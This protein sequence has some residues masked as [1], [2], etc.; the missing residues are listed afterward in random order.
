MLFRS[1]LND[2]IFVE[3]ARVFA[4]NAL[5][6]GGATF[7][8]RLDWVFARAVS[9]RP[10]PEERRALADL[11]RANLARF[12]AAPTEAAKLL[13][14]GDAPALETASVPELAALTTVTRT[15]L[16]LS[17]VITRY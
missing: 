11:Y 16:N 5:K 4:Q 7:D 3:A 1:L 13:Q 8:Q 9:R 6:D 15:V 12:E 10:A 17:E 2:P 14:V